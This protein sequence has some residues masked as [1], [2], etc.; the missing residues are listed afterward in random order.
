MAVNVE[1]SGGFGPKGIKILHGFDAVRLRP[2]MYFGALDWRGVLKAFGAVMDTMAWICASPVE[3][4]ILGRTPNPSTLDVAIDGRAFTARMTYHRSEAEALNERCFEV[5]D[6]MEN[7]T[8]AMD[9]GLNLTSAVSEYFRLSLHERGLEEIIAAHGR[10]EAEPVVFRDTQKSY[11]FVDYCLDQKF[12]ISGMSRDKVQGY[13]AGLSR[14]WA[15]LIPS[16]DTFKGA[17]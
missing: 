5:A 8:F 11:L 7:M 15:G 14:G 13:L 12:D 9:H 4:T 3:K 6:A 10:S 16:L 1:N 2:D 17:Q